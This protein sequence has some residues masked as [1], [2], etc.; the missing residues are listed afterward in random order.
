MVVVKAELGD[1][2]V[3]IYIACDKGN[4]KGISHFVKYLAYWC[5]KTKRVKKIMLDVDASA[6][7]SD[8]CAEAVDHSLKKIDTPLPAARKKLNGQCTDAGRGGGQ[9]QA[10]HGNLPRWT[11]LRRQGY[12]SSTCGLHA[13]NLTLKNPVSTLFGEGGLGERNALQLLHSAFNL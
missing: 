11:E 2:Q 12:M 7:T 9:E 5:R 10:S 8:G 4:K 1:M 13:H 6:G 3:K